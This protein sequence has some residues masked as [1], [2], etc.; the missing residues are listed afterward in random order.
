M[1]EASDGRRDGLAE[2]TI[3]LDAI[4][5]NWRRLAARAAPAQCGA[6]VKA[7]AYGCGIE[8]VVPALSMAGCRTFFVAHV[9]E[10][11]RVRQAL[12]DRG[13]EARILVLNGFHPET[14]PIADYIDAALDPV[15]GSPHELSAWEA[16]LVAAKSPERLSCALHVDTGMNRLGFPVEEAGGFTVERLAAARVDLVMSHLVSAEMPAE[17]VNARQIAAFEALRHGALGALPAS[18]A[19]SSG[20]FLP[21]RPHYALVRPGYALYGGNPTPDA[22]NPMRPA[23]RLETRVLQVRHVPAGATAGYNA[24]WT[25]ARP[26]RLATL[27]LGYADGLPMGASGLGR[28]GAP[29]FVG[30]RPCPI[31]GRISMDLTIVDVTDLPEGE[32]KPGLMAEILGEHAGIDDLARQA[33]TIGYEILTSLGHRYRRHYVGDGCGASAAQESRSRV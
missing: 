17:P 26:S 30:G 27:A 1:N 29:V 31:V 32:A 22:S 21:Q 23:V 3:D 25:A 11:R 24:R 12:R 10:G 28:H 7:D 4:G 20:I 19:N 33:G 9:S 8:A 15:I 14:A 2:L 13:A 16:L 5:E 6:A 18:L